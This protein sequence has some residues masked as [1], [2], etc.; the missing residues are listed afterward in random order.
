MELAMRTSH[1]STIILAAVGLLLTAAI[2]A[3]IL[4]P[5]TTGQ[6]A[7]PPIP[8]AAPPIPTAAPPIPTAAPPIPTPGAT[9]YTDRAGAGYVAVPAGN[10]VAAFR[11]GR[12]EVTN[13]QYAQCVAA[14]ACSLPR[15]A[16]SHG[17]AA[18]AAHPVISLTRD[19]AREY[20]AWVGGALP[21]EAQWLRACQDDDG[22]SYPWGAAAPDATRANFGRVAGGTA[23]V[24]SH[25]AGASP[26]GVLDMAGNVWEP[27]AAD[28]AFQIAR[29][30]AYFSDAGQI[31]CGARGENGHDDDDSTAGV[32]VV[33]AGP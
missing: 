14:G 4:L 22:R 8:T 11:I 15:D 3:L 21:T 6:P 10:G 17:D 20:A 18:R 32:R 25:P 1:G 31:A 19:Q 13:A 28:D 7:A 9:G 29:G 24:G 26:Y 23:A 33:L 12:T 16:A 5:G 2:G 27:V 30:G